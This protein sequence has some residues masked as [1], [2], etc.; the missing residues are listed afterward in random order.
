MRRTEV[1][2]VTQANCV[3]SETDIYTNKSTKPDLP[4]IR[5]ERENMFWLVLFFWFIAGVLVLCCNREVSKFEYSVCWAT[6][7]MYILGLA[8]GWI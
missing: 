8:T 7:L 6:L 1:T 2:V 3:M 5:G 4:G